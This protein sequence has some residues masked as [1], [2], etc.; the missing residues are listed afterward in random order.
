MAPVLR[1]IDGGHTAPADLPLDVVPVGERRLQ[2][3]EQ[4]G[5]RSDKLVGVSERREAVSVM[6]RRGLPLLIAIPNVKRT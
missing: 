5:H 6:L 4:L 1:D 3:V 2:L